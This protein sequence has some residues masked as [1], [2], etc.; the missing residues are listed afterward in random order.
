MTTEAAII[1]DIET[2]VKH[3]MAWTICITDDPRRHSRQHDY[4]AVSHNWDAVTESVARHIEGYFLGKGMQGARRDG[5]S[6]HH[7]CIYI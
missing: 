2:K 7:V 5:L 4:T 3:Y 1:R 6:P